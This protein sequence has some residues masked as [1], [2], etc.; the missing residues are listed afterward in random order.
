[1]VWRSGKTS[2]RKATL[3]TFKAMVALVKRK[4]KRWERRSTFRERDQSLQKP[5]G[6][7]DKIY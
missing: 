6:R 7:R 5:R 4:A 1:M 3:K 2:L